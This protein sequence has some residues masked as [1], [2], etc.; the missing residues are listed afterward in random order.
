MLDILENYVIISANCKGY[1]LY[2]HFYPEKNPLFIAY[3]TPLIGHLFLDDFEFIKFA[4]KYDELMEQT[5]VIGSPKKDTARHKQFG[6]VL[7][8]FSQTDGSYAILKCKDIDIHLI[9]DILNNQNSCEYLDSQ[10]NA[11]RSS[12]TL[13]DQVLAKWK[14]RAK[15][16][17]NKQKIF[18]WDSSSF[19][20]QHTDIERA[21]LI[22]RFNALNGWTFFLT[23]RPEEESESGTHI[24]KYLPRWQGKVQSDR[25]SVDFHLNWMEASDIKDFADLINA[26]IQT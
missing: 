7:Q 5:P 16:S 23:E 6:T 14:G 15:L 10:N 22:K 11:I 13:P 17:K 26:R 4:E 3:N 19:Q 21:E 9:H 12:W 18:I 2:R 24:I 8:N 1:F 25:S 20:T